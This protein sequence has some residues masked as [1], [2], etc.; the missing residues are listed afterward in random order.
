MWALGV[1]L[2]QMVYG[3]LPFWPPSGNHS[4][5]EIMVTHRELSFPPTSGVSSFGGGGSGVGAGAG[6]AGAGMSGVGSSSAVD[7]KGWKGVR[8]L[9]S[10]GLNTLE[11]YDPMAGYLRVSFRDSRG[12]GEVLVLSPRGVRSSRSM[13]YCSS[14]SVVPRMDPVGCC[15]CG[16]IGFCECM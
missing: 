1:T 11:A 3:T 15:F 8:T 2:Y 14:C 13:G 12:I 7:E 4:E 9:S 10:G 16:Q 6:G 5:L